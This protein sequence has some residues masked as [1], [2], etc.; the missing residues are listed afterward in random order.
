ML[1]LLGLQFTLATLSC[2]G[3]CLDVL[4][5][6]APGRKG[7]GVS[8]S[9]THEGALGSVPAR[10]S[11][12]FPLSDQSNEG[13]WAKHMPLWDEFAGEVLDE[14]KWTPWHR[15]W[16]GRQPAWFSSDNVT[17]AEEQLQ[18]TMRK[19]EPPESLRAKGYHTYSSAAVQATETVKYGYFE[20][21][22]QPMQSAGSSSF[23]FAGSNGSWRTEIDVFEIGG[24]AKGFENR[25]NMNLHVFQT[26]T[27]KKHWNV[28][29]H[30]IAP[31]KL[32]DDFHVYGLDWN[33]QELKYFVDGVLVRRVANTHW[34]QPLYL[35][36][37]SETMPNWLGLP[38]D[39]DLPSVYRVDYVRSWKARTTSENVQAA[40]A[41]A[42]H[43]N[44]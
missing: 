19:Q 14:T 9:W 37:D 42:A 2:V 20:V 27:S 11:E 30:W 29:G 3:I 36:F 32:A 23:W 12:A 28:G 24:K 31:F 17:I 7:E 35:I 4:A 44:K 25:Y 5:D 15:N 10:I 1:R 18:L 13:D 43:R 41:Q 16:K 40:A 8:E 34:H 39:K 38:E 22:A 21:R 33:E 26:P 6:V